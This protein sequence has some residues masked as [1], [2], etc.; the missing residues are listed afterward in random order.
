MPE[1]SKNVPLRVEQY[2]RALDEAASLPLAR[3]IIATKIA[4]TRAVVALYATNYP[5]P[6]MARARDEFERLEDKA[7]RAASRAELLGLEGAAAA[8]WFE[9]FARLN[10]SG[11]PFPGRRMNPSPDPVNAL[12]SLGYTF[13]GNELRT[14]VEGA[15]LEPHIGFLHQVDYG[16]PSLSLDLLEAFR[17]PVI[18]RL[19][20]RLVNKGTLRAENFGRSVAGRGAGRVVLNPASFE[21]YLRAYE[22]T[23]TASRKGAPQGIRAELA[24]QVEKLKAWLAG[25]ELFQPW[26]E[27]AGDVVP[28]EL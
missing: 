14:L 17:V 24:G 12:L 19:T 4:N 6:E 8:Q 5:G 1:A 25:G 2:R 26:R 22:E 20:L 3:S 10:R 7:A 13:L 23:V 27:E 15:G 9:L 21:V 18:D 11:M 16:R 28:G